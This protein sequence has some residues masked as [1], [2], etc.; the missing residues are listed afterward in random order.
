MKEIFSHIRLPGTSAAQELVS[1]IAEDTLNGRLETLTF[2]GL[3]PATQSCAEVED[4]YSDSSL[5][6]GLLLLRGLLVHGI[7]VHV[8]NQQRWRVDYGLDLLAKRPDSDMFTS[9]GML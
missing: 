8:L 4:A 6:K 2:V 9:A 3:V 1:L 5:L 7:L